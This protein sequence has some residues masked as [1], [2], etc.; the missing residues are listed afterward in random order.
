MSAKVLLITPPFTQLNTPYPATTYLKGFL[1][2]KEIPSYQI[3]LGLE[4]ILKIFSSHGLNEIFN[5][6]L[7]IQE[8]SDNSQRIQALKDS[9]I[10]VIDDVILFLKGNDETLAYRICSDAYLP[11]ASRFSQAEDLDWSFGNMGIR[12]KARHLATLLLEDLSDF[13][14]ETIDPHFGFSRYAER[15]SSSAFSF[16][17][18]YEEVLKE[19]SLIIQHQHKIIDDCIQQEQPSIV[20][21]TVPFPGNLFSALKCGQYLKGNYPNIKICMG[22]GYANTELRSLSDTRIFEFIDYIT[23][24]DGETPL[25]NLIE[26]I[27]DNSRPL[28]RTLIKADNKVEYI[29][30][31]SS[32][33]ISLKQEISP[34]YNNIKVDNYLS[35]IEITNP[36]HRL[37][38]DGF[39][40]KL[41]MAHGCYWGRCTF[42]DTTL[43]YIARFEPVTAKVL[44][45]KMETI[46]EQTGQSGFHFVDEAAPPALMIALAK[47][48]IKRKLNFTWWTNIRFESSFT[49]DVCTLLKKSG[50]IAVSGG[51]EVA[52][53]RI[54]SLINKGVS[55]EKVAQVCKNLTSAGILTHA[56]LM[57]GFPTQTDQETIDSLEVVR[58]LFENQIVNSGFWHQF[59]MTAHSPVGQ[60]PEKFQVEAKNPETNSF[61]NN[62]LEHIDST[63]ASHHLY[64][65]GLKKSL[66]NYMLDVGFD[67]PLQDWFDFKIPRTKIPYDLIHN[68]IS[69]IEEDNSPNRKLIWT[70][71]L[72]SL[73]LYSKKKKGKSTKMCELIFHLRES[74]EIINTKESLGQWIIE[75]LGKCSIS[76]VLQPTIADTQKEFEKNELGDF[77]IFW[78][79]YTLQQ[80]KQLGLLTI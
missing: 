29:D 30:N 42:C 50:C 22:G 33:D 25:L 4:V 73:R 40:N 5:Q 28:K 15:L 55:V 75:L 65:E 34:S 3:D 12:D 70:E 49:S 66:Y 35:F 14:V 20:A 8:L 77:T 26:H 51:L 67:L 44:C 61:A 23:L 24:D 53:N 78:K 72:P 36:M 59:A 7:N 27:S 80:L 11:K 21:I 52:S 71:N 64:S 2:H 38:S 19:D 62:D 47:E 54:L 39:W 76:Q 18:I 10:E 60:N 57:Y 45:N 56:Y 31:S 79:S 41:T 74:T 58:Q 13:I 32:K 68:S 69:V 16:T 17:P 6:A 46:Y 9:Y 48:L 37:W 1:E 43:D 63:G